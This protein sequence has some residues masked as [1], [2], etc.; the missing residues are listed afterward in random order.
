MGFSR[1]EY[2]SGWPFPSPS[3]EGELW[4]P[5]GEFWH[6]QPKTWKP[7]EAAAVPTLL[8]R[9]PEPHP[10]CWFTCGQSVWPKQKAAGNQAA[11]WGGVWRVLWKWNWEPLG[12][13]LREGRQELLLL[14]GLNGALY[15]VKAFFSVASLLSPQRR[16]GARG[17]GSDHPCCLSPVV[18]REGSAGHSSFWKSKISLSHTRHSPPFSPLPPTPSH[19]SAQR[20]MSFLTHLLASTSTHSDLLCFFIV[21]NYVSH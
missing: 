18:L 4:N 17:G 19:L 1:Q 5:R 12:D 3:K 10:E 2:Q 15:W 20:Y 9:L 11:F 7:R 14:W 21:V 13:V 16:D 8:P 6:R